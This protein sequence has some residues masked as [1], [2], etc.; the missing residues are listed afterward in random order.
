MSFIGNL[1]VRYKVLAFSLIATVGF[2]AYLS[3]GYKVVSDNNAHLAQLNEVDFKV[4]ELVNSNWV[5]LI[6][7][8][9]TFTWALFETSDELLEEAREIGTQINDSF[10]EIKRIS[11]KS[12][13]HINA[14]EKDFKQYLSLA[15][16]V[17]EGSINETL[18]RTQ[19]RSMLK[20]MRT[21]YQSFKSKQEI[22]KK[23]KTRGFSA[24]L[25][26]TQDKSEKSMMV[27]IAIASS[28]II[29][30]FLMGLLL[31][32]LIVNPLKKGISI[33]KEISEGNWN[34]D[35]NVDSKDEI[36]SLLLS[37]RGMRDTLR[38]RIQEDLSR[39]NKSLDR[40]KSAL[41]NASTY[42]VIAD[43][44]GDILYT[45]K[46]FQKLLLSLF[47][48]SNNHTDNGQALKDIHPCFSSLNEKVSAL[49]SIHKERI[50]INQRTFDVVLN[51]VVN[52]V[53]QKI[54]VTLEWAELTTDLK[55][56]LELDRVVKS[57][58]NGD[59]SQ[60][61]DVSIMDGVMA[62]LGN[63]MNTLI[64]ITD[65]GLSETG[66]VLRSISKGFLDKKVEKNFPGAFGELAQYC[67]QTVDSL[68]HMI[69]DLNKLVG[70]ANKGVFSA[71]ILLDKDTQNTVNSTEDESF[72]EQLATSLNLLMQNT[73]NGLIDVQHILS[74][75]AKGNLT[76]YMPT[77][78]EGS[79]SQLS[80]D[81]N[82]TVEQLTKII[83]SIRNISYAF[84][85][86][87]STVSDVNAS[88]TE[89][90]DEQRRSLKQTQEKMMNMVSLVDSS[91]ARVS[92][93]NAKTIEATGIAKSGGYEV[94][95]AIESMDGIRE[96]SHKISDI[97][98]VINDIAF[99]T[100][101]LA[102]N[103]AVEAARAGEHGKGFSVVAGEV[104]NLAKRC[105]TSAKQIRGLIENSL[106]RIEH[107][108]KV[109]N[110]CGSTL[111]SIIASIDTVNTMTE[112][113]SVASKQQEA[114][115]KDVSY[116]LNEMSDVTEKN[117]GL[118]SQASSSSQ[119]M[120]QLGREM[121]T[122]LDYFS[123]KNSE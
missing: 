49:A 36:G 70:S 75:I 45:N 40:I 32:R 121:T 66:R 100:N 97:I 90:S 119:S 10:L 19:K 7:I 25:Q 48:Q 29:I 86:G 83:T 120:A 122:M 59:F 61:V 76:E 98:S 109:V 12:I 91:Y 94:K 31:T 38:D 106:E 54:G 56:Q 51:P 46:A 72:F 4:L 47:G 69:G 50:E 105:S 3:F 63:G 79:F 81:T 113:I 20:Q 114:S 53:N 5:N 92:E 21:A 115:I 87:T 107:G 24:T 8:E 96:S 89:K 62:K 118:V 28:V 116:A 111:T 117:I 9:T 104:G 39:Q 34:V 27:G 30:L 2:V 73:E 43:V 23:E 33:V 67:N 93:V 71:R 11:P 103:A 14:I 80:N 102:L 35:V 99:Q 110:K 74:Q 101:L 88:L 64:D 77:H 95:Q 52:N 26:S 15:I 6:R 44:N 108:A 65:E 84:A 17:V 42:T 123:L 112:E 18:D 13:M 68:N 85:Q 58:I 1:A 60:R 55:V 57:T 82:Q 37:I 22:F 16:G 41:D 78:Y